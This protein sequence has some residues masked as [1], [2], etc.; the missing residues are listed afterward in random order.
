LVLSVAASIFGDGLFP[1]YSPV[2]MW[3]QAQ[4][5]PRPKSDAGI[6]TIRLSSDGRLYLND[7]PVNINLLANEIKRRFPTA[8]EVYVRLRKNTPWDLV[9][10]VS[11]QLGAAKPPI[12]VRF[13]DF[14]KSK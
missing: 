3:A 9:S 10:Q 5:A 1:F 4:A 12:P 2:P 7:K 13:V 14:E 6:P 11:A 8:S